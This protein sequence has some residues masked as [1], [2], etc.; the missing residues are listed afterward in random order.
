MFYEIPV[1][2]AVLYNLVTQ[3]CFFLKLI[4]WLADSLPI[5]L[6][7]D[8]PMVLAA[9]KGRGMQCVAIEVA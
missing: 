7:P 1:A 9:D 2:R 3:D 5:L 8:S 4:C 6:S